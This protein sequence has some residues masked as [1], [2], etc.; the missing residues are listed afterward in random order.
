MSNK[1]TDVFSNQ[2]T[3]KLLN[4]YLKKFKLGKK[5]PQD[6]IELS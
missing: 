3:L 2:S 4:V 6:D 1:D 5:K